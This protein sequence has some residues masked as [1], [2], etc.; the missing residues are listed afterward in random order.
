MT[1]KTMEFRVE[2]VKKSGFELYKVGF[3]NAEEDSPEQRDKFCASMARIAVILS[4][5]IMRGDYSDVK[6]IRAFAKMDGADVIF[7][8]TPP[9]EGIVCEEDMRKFDDL[10]GHLLEM[11]QGEIEHTAPQIF[12]KGA[13]ESEIEL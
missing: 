13:S 3:T 7:L 4:E 5:N 9:V 12:M 6:E 1:V 8:R 11:L 2:V 10:L